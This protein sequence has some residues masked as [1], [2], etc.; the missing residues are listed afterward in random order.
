MKTYVPLCIYLAAFFLEWEMFEIKVVEK[1]KT[2]FVFNNFFFE[3][4]VVH[5]MMWKNMVE[6]DRSHMAI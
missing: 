6:P 3:N 5:D 1:T 4:R 2:H